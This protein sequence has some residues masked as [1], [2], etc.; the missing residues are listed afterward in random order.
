[1]DLAID[2]L[3]LQ[4]PIEM[5]YCFFII[6]FFLQLSGCWIPVKKLKIYGKITFGGGKIIS[7]RYLLTYE[8]GYKNEYFKWLSSA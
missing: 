2:L 7:V 5:I 1:M 4:S 3:L 6:W 8:S